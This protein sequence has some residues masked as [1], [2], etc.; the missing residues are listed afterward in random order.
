MT[1][2]LLARAVLP[3]RVVI[4]GLGKRVVPHTEDDLILELTQIDATV[5]EQGQPLIATL[6]ADRDATGPPLLSIG[7]GAGEAFWFIPV[8]GVKT[9][10]VTYSKGPRPD[11]GSEVAF[12]YGTGFSEYL[13]WM[14]IPKQ[15]AYVAAIE[16]F[17]TGQRPT[18]VEWADL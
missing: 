7:L 10:V 12:R 3:E 17:R 4:D 6:Y 2:D 18:S 9:R 13:G 15:T 16:F 5:R 1:S 14:L 8:A 11:D